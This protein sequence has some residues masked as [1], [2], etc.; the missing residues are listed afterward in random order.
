V[1]IPVA[2]VGVVA[3]TIGECVAYALG[4]GDARTRRLAFE[5]DR[6]SHVRESEARPSHGDSR[7]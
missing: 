1:L 4:A 6:R 3:H 2:T 5:L 7:V